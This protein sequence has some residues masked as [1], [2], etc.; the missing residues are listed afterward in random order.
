MTVQKGDNFISQKKIYEW[1]EIIKGG[2]ASFVAYA[3]S[4]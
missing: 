1:V 2:W 4:W 3:L